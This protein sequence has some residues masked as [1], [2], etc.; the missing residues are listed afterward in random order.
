MGLVRARARFADNALKFIAAV[1]DGELGR[2]REFLLLGWTSDPRGL[3]TGNLGHVMDNGHATAPGSL[4]GN[5]AVVGGTGDGGVRDAVR[6]S[7]VEDLAKVE[8][9]IP[10]DSDGDADGV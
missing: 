10:S 7:G 2:I 8:S 9:E 5:A 6:D 4:A 3:R 1:D